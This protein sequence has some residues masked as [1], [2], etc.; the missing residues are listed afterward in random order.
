MPK[1]MQQPA[2]FNNIHTLSQGLTSHSCTPTRANLRSL[3]IFIYSRYWLS[4]S[5]LSLVHFDTP[6]SF[7]YFEMHRSTSR[8]AISLIT[9]HDQRCKTVKQSVFSLCLFFGTATFSLPRCL[10]GRKRWAKFGRTPAQFDLKRESL[11]EMGKTGLKGNDVMKR[12][13]SLIATAE[14]GTPNRPP[15]SSPSCVTRAGLMFGS[16]L[17]PLWRLH[18][19]IPHKACVRVGAFSFQYG[20]FTG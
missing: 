20:P 1:D 8:D 7:A 13:F 15:F 17:L 14:H 5:F 12:S 16:L 4:G 6:N 10:G 3:L 2:P 18:L 19:D 9:Q 11:D